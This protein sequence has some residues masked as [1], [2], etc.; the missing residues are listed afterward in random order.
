[1]ASG[2]A[3]GVAK[4]T[5]S[6]PG[7]LPAA[8]PAALIASRRALLE[9]SALEPRVRLDR[10]LPCRVAKR[11]RRQIAKQTAWTR[12]KEDLDAITL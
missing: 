7:E 3:Y 4:Y 11:L 9:R 2:Y 10:S 5:R 12:L 1:M 6:S 8:A